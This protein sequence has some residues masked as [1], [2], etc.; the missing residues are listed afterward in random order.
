MSKQVDWLDK[1]ARDGILEKQMLIKS[2]DVRS[3]SLSIKQ[4]PSAKSENHHNRRWRE[5]L[6][7]SKCR[8]GLKAVKS[9][10]GLYLIELHTQLCYWRSL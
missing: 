2:A 6:I 10:A 8:A 4:W 9:W 1:P 7:N 3:L 5:G